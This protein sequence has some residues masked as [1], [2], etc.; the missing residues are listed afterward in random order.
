MHACVCAKLLQVCPTLGDPMDHGPSG[1]SVHGILQA[2]ILEWVAIPSSSGFSPPRDQARVSCIGRRVL[3]HWP[4]LGSPLLTM[5]G[6]NLNSTHFALLLYLQSSVIVPTKC[7]YFLCL[8][9]FLPMLD[10]KIPDSRVMLCPSLCSQYSSWGLTY[11]RCYNFVL[12]QMI[13][14]AI[15]NELSGPEKTFRKDSKAKP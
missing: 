6:V 13:F 4:H 14:R 7:Y 2:K 15:K 5:P 10:S 11:C 3:Y 9:P 8:S 1:S 12:K